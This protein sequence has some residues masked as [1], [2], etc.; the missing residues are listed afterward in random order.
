MNTHHVIER[1]RYL[2]FHAA[3][4]RPKRPWRILR[5]LWSL[6]FL[7][8]A[9][10]SA[11]LKG[12][13]GLGCRLR[14]ISFGM[15]ALAAGDVRRACLLVTYPMDSFRYFEF[16]FA[17][18]AAR[19]ATIGRYLDVSSPRLLPFMVLKSRP[20]LTGDLLNPQPDDLN[21]TAS[22]A[23]STGLRARCRL[24]GGLIENAPFASETFD[25]IT[26]ISVVEH[27]PQ[28]TQAIATM[29]R[30]LRPNGKLVVTVPCARE[31]CEEYTNLD[32]YELLSKDKEG[33][34][35]WQR[36]Y[37]RAALTERIWSI[38]GE[39]ARMRIFG[40][41][42]VGSYDHN[43]TLKRTD[44][45][46]PFWREPIMMAADYR[47][48]ETLEELPGMGVIAMEFIKPATAREL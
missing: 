21:D 48:F 36:Y 47:I 15:R 22:V 8:Y 20:G 28:D 7:P 4:A 19:G 17:F 16:D 9:L 44:P 32:D 23:V 13:P 31:S 6:M 14:C 24:V 45:T 33:Y 30:L 1:R 11:W 46:Y 2:T 12:V 38:T 35:Y 26:S 42:K 10:A 3:A 37:D 18:G 27:I 39:P 29:W 41:R 25:L 43:V 5:L 40:E 34:V